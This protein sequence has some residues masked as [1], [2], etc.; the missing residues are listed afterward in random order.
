M[1]DQKR[2][3]GGFSGL[4]G[5][6]S[7]RSKK[8]KSPTQSP[9]EESSQG[10][11]PAYGSSQYGSAAPTGASEKVQPPGDDMKK[12]TSN[13]P[14]NPLP[15]VLPSNEP[16]DAYAGLK[17]Y[18]I[19]FLIDDSGSMRGDYPSRWTQVSGTLGDIAEICTKQD[20]DGIDIYFL[21][22]RDEQRF[23]NVKEYIP[24]H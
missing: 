11:L 9:Q 7:L 13:A 12:D 18:D 4:M 17:D 1:S 8:D 6:M 2:S 21:N 5:K 16:D 23:K 15:E 20:D 19:V 10:A 3:S 22:Q 14:T 24:S